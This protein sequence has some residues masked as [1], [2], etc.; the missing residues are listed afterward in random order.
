M[1]DHR[2]IVQTIFFSLYT[3]DD[4]AAGQKRLIMIRIVRL[5][6][7]KDFHRIMPPIPFSEIEGPT[8]AQHVK[9]GIDTENMTG[10]SV[11]QPSLANGDI[12][13]AF[14]EESYMNK[15]LD[16]SGFLDWTGIDDSEFHTV[17]RP[18]PMFD[19]DYLIRKQRAE[20]DRLNMELPGLISKVIYGNFLQEE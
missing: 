19:R 11:T 8:M 13:V 18:S 4:G 14:E 9:P 16:F 5:L 2:E 1:D 12:G 10:E 6:G 17:Q 15:Q 7:L 20:N 3:R